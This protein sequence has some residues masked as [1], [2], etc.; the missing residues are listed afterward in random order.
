MRV[1][2]GSSI[3]LL[4]A[5]LLVSTTPIGTGA[6]IHQFDLVHPLFAHV[7]VVNGRMLTHE[8]MQRGDTRARPA[9]SGVSVGAADGAATAGGDLGAIATDRP[10]DT[11]NIVLVWEGARIAWLGRLPA[12]RREAP[13][14]PPPTFSASTG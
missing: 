4:L 3:A 13:P 6:G 9:S 1:L 5:L 12:D 10:I 8:Q 14:D 11:P 7:H 2:P